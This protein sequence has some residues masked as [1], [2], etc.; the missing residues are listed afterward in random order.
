MVRIGCSG[1]QYAAWRGRFYDA[2]L[3]PAQW[4]EHY[5]SVFD[6]VEVNNTFYRLPESAVFT[7]WRRMAPP[8][9]LFAVKA[10]RFLTHLKRLVNPEEPLER[11]LTRAAAL[12]PTLGPILY[13]LPPTLGKNLERLDQFLAV[14]VRVSRRIG[15]RRRHLPRVRHVVEFRH[16]SWYDRDVFDRLDAHGIAC[17]AHDRAGSQAPWRDGG[18][19]AYVRFHGAS[20][21]YA[22][23]YGAEGLA[24]WIDRIAGA[25]QA[26]RSVYVYFNND[27]DAAAPRDAARLK[28]ML[29]SRIAARDHDDEVSRWRD[30]RHGRSGTRSLGS[31]T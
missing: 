23:E 2:N 14:L 30:D 4:F 18:P 15:R 28:A 11:L 26:G 24:P 6:T 5:S 29:A 25:A 9:F 31:V 3:R 13:Q 20:G 21:H 10:S 16:P 7:R 1:W 8:G 22:G 17:C 27:P 12:G 19:F